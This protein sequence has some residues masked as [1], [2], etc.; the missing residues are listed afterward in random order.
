MLLPAVVDCADLHKMPSVTFSIAGKDFTL[1]P[2]QYI[3]KVRV[4]LCLA[5]FLGR[6]NGWMA[7]MRFCSMP[8]LP[9]SVH[10]G[11]SQPH[12]LLTAYL[13]ARPPAR[14]HMC[15]SRAAARLSA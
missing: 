7:R 14:M 3:L 8:F 10:S 11:G 15:R 12:P 4:V 2:E 13:P 1:T 5:S 6:V 9:F